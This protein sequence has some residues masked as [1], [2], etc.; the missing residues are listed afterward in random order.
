[1]I[2]LV[3]AGALAMPSFLKI[4]PQVAAGLMILCAAAAVWTGAYRAAGIIAAQ[5]CMG[6]LLVNAAARRG[7]QQKR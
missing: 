5:A 4:A 7:K 3:P 2:T 6:L 1:M